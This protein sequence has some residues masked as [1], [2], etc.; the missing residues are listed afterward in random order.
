M[1]KL[2]VIFRN[3]ANAPK[4][5]QIFIEFTFIWLNI[6]KL[7]ERRKSTFSY[8]I[9]IFPPVAICHPRRWR[10]SPPP[11]IPLYTSAAY[12]CR[13]RTQ[14]WPAQRI[15]NTVEG[16]KSRLTTVVCELLSALVEVYASLVRRAVLA[17]RRWEQ[18]TLWVPT[19][20]QRKLQ[21][22]TSEFSNTRLQIFMPCISLPELREH[23]RTDAEIVP[24]VFKCFSQN[25]S[26][27]Q[28]QVY[29]R[30]GRKGSEGEQIYSSTL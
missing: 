12:V 8:K 9:S 4:R 18:T 28:R 6:L 16:K 13:I 15:R 14:N 21:I 1:T 2:I 3:F 19:E 22:L 7:V 5:S 11:A 17:D 30:T 24:F 29:P 23:R 27:R 26:R 10:H 25:N 20:T